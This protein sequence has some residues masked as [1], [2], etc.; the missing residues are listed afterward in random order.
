MVNPKKD[1]LGFIS[2]LNSLRGFDGIER[3]TFQNIIRK[4]PSNDV[5]SFLSELGKILFGASFFL[6][7]I[8]FLIKKTI[9]E[10]Q[11]AYKKKLISFINSEVFCPAD[12]KIPDAFIDQ[13]F[14]VSLKQIDFNRDLLDDV[15]LTGTGTYIYSGEINDLNKTIKNAIFSPQNW[16]GLMTLTY[17]RLGT[18]DGIQMPDVFNIKINESY[19]GIS[20]RLFLRN[21]I[22]SNVFI[23]KTSLLKTL[24][25]LLYGVFDKRDAKR[26]AQAADVIYLNKIAAEPKERLPDSYYLFSSQDFRKISSSQERE[27]SFPSPLTSPDS[28]L[29]EEDV[30]DAINTITEVSTQEG[31]EKNKEEEKR[32]KKENTLRLLFDSINYHLFSPKNMLVYSIIF[33]LST[34]SIGFYDKE[35]FKTRKRDFLRFM[36]KDNI[37]DF[38]SKKIFEFLR[39]EIVRLLAMEKA[40]KIREKATFKRITLKSLVNRR[41]L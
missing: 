5:L 38:F 19:R 21:V 34:G 4:S 7:R 26:K 30:A 12:G 3:G 28:I 17:V 39:I 11:Q 23:T 14:N 15:F 24:Y 29:V 18:V 33:K 41:G 16:Q 20:S 2:A 13:G 9:F 25:Q 31:T 6:D 37:T 22:D 8:F 1:I 36:I 32:A 40:A 35:G 27:F 10:F